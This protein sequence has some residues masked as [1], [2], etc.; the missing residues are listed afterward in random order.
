MTFEGLLRR[1][2]KSPILALSEKM[3]DRVFI[4]MILPGLGVGTHTSSIDGNV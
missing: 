2:Y 1:S 3:N 4:L